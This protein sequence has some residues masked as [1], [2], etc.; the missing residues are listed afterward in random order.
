V[1]RRCR[2]G[3]ATGA[4]PTAPRWTKASARL[5]LARR[6]FQRYAADLPERDPFPN[7]V[8]AAVVVR[9]RSYLRLF[10]GSERIYQYVLSEASKQN[11]PLQFN[12]KFPGSAAYVVDSYEVPGAFTKGGAIFILDALT[13]VDKYLS[14]DTWVIG[15]DAAAVDK[16]KIVANLKAQY[17]TEYAA[18]WRMFLQSASVVR[19]DNVKDAAAKL[20]VLSGNASPLLQLLS[21]VSQNT[22]IALPE[23]ASVFQPAQTVTP[24]TAT[25][26]LIGGLNRPY[27]GALLD[28]QAALSQTAVGSGK[29][30][31]EAAAQASSKVAAAKTAVLQLANGFTVDQQGNVHRTVQ[32]LLEAPITNTDPLL[33]HF[34]ADEINVKARSFCGVAKGLLAKYPFNPDATEQASIAEVSAMFKPVT[35]TLWK[36]YNDNLKAVLPKTGNQYVPAGGNVKISTGFVQFMNHAQTF[37]DAV[38]KDENAEPH[39][40]LTIEPS[41]TAT[42]PT[43]SLTVDGEL[44]RSSMNGN[45]ATAKLDWPNA[46]KET[47]LTTLLGTTEV[48]VAGP[49]SGPWALFQL[50]GQATDWHSGSKP[51]SLRVGWEFNARNQRGQFVTVQLDDATSA[52][53]VLRRGLFSGSACSGDI[54]K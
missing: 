33:Q 10:A 52:A 5:V 44:F 45:M 6:Q 37:T 27:V 40:S 35:G 49:Y 48:P 28:L 8:D 46:G 2:A 32:S 39:I 43:V 53:A 31:E 16:N 14:G 7:S 4:R 50:F 36:F 19:Y 11:P 15:E 20:A 38:F 12:R 42:F 30:A 1:L 9:A 18:H 3:I 29:A 34:G 13:S 17:A 47:K 54:A 21:T 26:K 41:P 51:G 25:D 22:A 24:P 23:V